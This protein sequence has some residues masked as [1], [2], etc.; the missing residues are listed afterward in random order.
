MIV[1]NGVWSWFHHGLNT[2]DNRILI[3]Y[4]LIPVQPSRWWT[5][6]FWVSYVNAIAADALASYIT[7]LTATKILTRGN[8]SWGRISFKC[9]CCASQIPSFVFMC[10]HSMYISRFAKWF[11]AHWNGVFYLPK[12]L[13][14]TIL[15]VMRIS[16]FPQTFY[17]KKLIFCCGLLSA[18]VVSRGV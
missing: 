15:L 18:T 2:L 10:I 5:G 3:Q 12:T 11:G 14:W 1:I 16:S 8:L 7:G 6:I 13:E 9:P 17:Y 4:F